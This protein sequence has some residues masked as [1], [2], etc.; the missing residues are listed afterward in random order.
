MFKTIYYFNVNE[1]LI[2]G[3]KVFC[4]DMESNTVYCLNEQTVTAYFNL[5]AEAK[6]DD[7]KYIF[8]YREETEGEKE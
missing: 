5:M 4:L 6:K 2:N 7:S 1:R 8:Y 3:E